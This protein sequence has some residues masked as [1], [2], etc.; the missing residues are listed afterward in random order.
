MNP[1]SKTEFI[2]AKLKQEGSVSYLDQPEHLAAI[3]NMNKNLEVTRR[4]FQVKDRN[5]HISAAQVVL[6]A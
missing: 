6:T 5:T 2:K 1:I 3:A 4:D